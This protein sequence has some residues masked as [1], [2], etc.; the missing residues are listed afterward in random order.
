MKGKKTVQ[1]YELLPESSFEE[2]HLEW[3]VRRLTAIEFRE[4]ASQA[5]WQHD[6]RKPQT[7]VAQR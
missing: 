3:L 5:V 2:S 6:H 1:G 7:D 4:V